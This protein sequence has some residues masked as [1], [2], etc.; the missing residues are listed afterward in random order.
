[1][2]VLKTI[3]KVGKIEKCMVPQSRESREIFGK[4]ETM[5]MAP[6][7]DQFRGFES[8]LQALSVNLKSRFGKFH[9]NKKPTKIF[10]YFCPSSLKWVK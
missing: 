1:M 2:G 10:L 7:R 5:K 3:L 6:R 9:L 8:R 4:T